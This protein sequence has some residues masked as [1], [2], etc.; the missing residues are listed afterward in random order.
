M[1]HDEERQ[2]LLTEYQMLEEDISRRTIANMT[3]SSILVPSSL[4]ILAVAIEFKES[5][6]AIFPFEIHAAG[7]LPLFSCLLI[8]YAAF[9]SYMTNRIIE[10]CYIRMNEIETILNLKG[11]KHIYSILRNAWYYKIWKVMRALLLFLAL[12]MSIIASIILFI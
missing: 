9:Y 1:L 6:N 8:L 10:I 7:F 3:L 2:N 4:V 12:T 5:L 11:H